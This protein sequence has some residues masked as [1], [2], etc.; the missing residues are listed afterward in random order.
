[1]S[2]QTFGGSALRERG[3]HRLP[4]GAA[5]YPSTLRYAQESAWREDNRREANGHQV[6]RV[7]KLAL[8]KGKSV[9]FSGYWQR[10]EA[11]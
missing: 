1:M 4:L 5:P 6:K 2:G 9:D 11:K 10:H 7:V 3:P 8:G